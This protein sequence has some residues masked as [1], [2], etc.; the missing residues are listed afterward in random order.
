MRGGTWE[1]YLTG[2]QRLH[3]PAEGATD[4]HQGLWA[5]LALTYA[6]PEMNTWS[7]SRTPACCISD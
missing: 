1:V 7:I 3:A 6:P 2:Q 5:F 4:P